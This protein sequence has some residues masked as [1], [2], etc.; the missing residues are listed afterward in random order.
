MKLTD[1]REILGAIFN[2]IL[3][4]ASASS[5]LISACELRAYT[6]TSKPLLSK[7][8]AATKPSP[9][10]P[11]E[12]VKMRILTG[13]E[14]LNVARVATSSDIDLPAFSIKHKRESP[15][16]SQLWSATIIS[17]GSIISPKINNKFER[18][19]FILRFFNYNYI[20]LN[21]K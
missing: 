8:L 9:P 19:K 11:P 21:I 1:K 5:D 16:Y 14:N 3:R 4:F 10:F 17:I 13:Y 6:S 7:C 2:R 18:K 12:P 15:R 20:F